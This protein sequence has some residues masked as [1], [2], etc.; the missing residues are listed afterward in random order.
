[1]SRFD[2]KMA[3]LAEAIKSKN[4]D[5]TGK[6]SVQAMIDA[7][8][9]ITA[10]DDIGEYGYFTGERMF[11]AVTLDGDMPQDSGD[12]IEI[13]EGSVFLYATGQ[14]EP[15]YS[16]ITDATAADVAYGKTVVLNGM[17]VTGAMPTSSISVKDNVVTITAGKIAER[18][19]TVGTALAAKT[20]TP[21]SE[22]IVIKAG[23]YL[24]GDQTIEAVEDNS[25]DFSAATSDFS[26]FLAVG[27]RAYNLQLI[28]FL[29]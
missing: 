18:E 23:Q 9:D 2:E 24:T 13:A 5:V 27:Q 12:A 16:I 15:D 17:L 14:D 3:E 26:A 6:L 7:V 8:E 20:Y 1:M 22:P 29:P 4:S 25:F 19:V 21:G 11:Q 28:F 10:G